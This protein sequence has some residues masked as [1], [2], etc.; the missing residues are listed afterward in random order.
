MRFLFTL[1]VI[2][3]SFSQVTSVTANDGLF[4]EVA[5]E[6][7]FEKKQ[8][9]IAETAEIA[10]DDVLPRITSTASLVA[11]LK[12]AGFEAQK[13]GEKASMR[14]RQ[15]GWNLPVS[16]TVQ[17]EQDR[18]V[19]QLSLAK[20][21]NP[22]TDNN[23]LLKLL[24][25][26]DAGRG[27]FFAYNGKSKFILLRS[28]LSNRLV[29]P[30]QLREH[31][32]NLG[33]LAEENAES[34]SVFGKKTETPK[35]APAAKPLALHGSWTA[36][37]GKDSFAIKLTA[38]SKFQLVHLKSGK[39]TISK[40]KVTRSGSQLTLV[41]DDGTKLQC[42]VAQTTKDRFQLSIVGSK[43]KTASKLEFKKAK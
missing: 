31:L 6:A 12:S 5:M 20:I 30:S 25:A 36:S 34:W 19:T 7:V 41:G 3:A 39:P 15:G 40:G 21:D 33:S 22:P 18:I 1:A 10:D 27:M 4:S 23:Q 42:L 9:M 38:D 2:T 26:G 13:E 8:N 29:T 11:A 16:M 14:L 37:F 24:A 32:Q 28:S 43:G 35:Q 17:V